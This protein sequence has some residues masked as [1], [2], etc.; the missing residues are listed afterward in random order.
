LKPNFTLNIEY[1][2]S[3]DNYYF[4]SPDIGILVVSKNIREGLQEVVDDLDALYRAYVST[5]DELTDVAKEL[6]KLIKAYH[7]E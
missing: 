1:I 3:E 5:A 6:A 7:G 4:T 2:E